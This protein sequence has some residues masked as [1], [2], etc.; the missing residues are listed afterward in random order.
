MADLECQY[1]D[2]VGGN[3]KEVLNGNIPRDDLILATLSMDKGKRGYYG[4]AVTSNFA[5][6]QVAG[7]RSVLPYIKICL[8]WVHFWLVYGPE[9]GP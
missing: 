9:G 7:P 3:D 5:F 1:T 2:W 6:L 8:C 4:G